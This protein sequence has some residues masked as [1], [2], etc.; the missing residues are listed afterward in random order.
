MK[1]AVIVTILALF[2][3]V[4]GAAQNQNIESTIV[5]TWID[6]HNRPWIFRTDGTMTWGNYHGRFTGAQL[7]FMDGV[8]VRIF[9]ISV[10]SDGLTMILSRYGSDW[11]HFLVKH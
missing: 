3:I 8:T 2:V 6:Q 7:A 1:K 9:N 4:S 10:S 5:G 11:G